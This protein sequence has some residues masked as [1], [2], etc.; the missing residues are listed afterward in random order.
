MFE[1]T[2]ALRYLRS[3]RKEGFASLITILSFLGIFLGVMVLIIVT[4]I[5]SG[6]RQELINSFIGIDGH[7][8]ISG[9][10]GS[11][12]AYPDYIQQIKQI[13]GVT[14]ARAIAEDYTLISTQEGRA[15][16]ASIRGYLPDDL[17]SIEEFAKSVS[18]AKLQELAIN[19]ENEELPRIILGSGLAYQLGIWEEGQRITLMS[20]KLV[21]TPFG[22][23]YSTTDFWVSGLFTTGNMRYDD[24]FALMDF[25]QAAW[26]LNLG[27]NASKIDVFI[28]NPSAT[29]EIAKQIYGLNRYDIFV[30]TW[31]NQY[32]DIVAAIEV[33][34]NIAVLIVGL[35]ILVSAFTIIS[36]L[37]MLVHAKTKDIGILRTIG[38]TQGQIRRIFLLSGFII[39]IFGTSFGA[40]FGVV[41]AHNV[42]AVR[43]FL[44]KTFGLNLFPV[45]VFNMPALPSDV[46]YSLVVILCI[47]TIMLTLLA[48]IYPAIRAAK[49]DP[50][51]ALKHD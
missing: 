46:S 45:S 48:S 32:G 7:I 23:T 9:S 27:E 26:F 50:A 4:S 30:Q 20:S 43:L 35:V 28:D 8:S 13:K 14:G 44:N 42:D 15:A 22:P 39:G 41:I 10:E 51:E 3:R 37:V 11:I 34:G 24:F 25:N 1:L 12:A 29:Q 21:E 31:Q 36:S 2:M 18:K 16:P 40:V 38:A 6:F 33:E 19:E 49:I 17:I 5:F 47:A